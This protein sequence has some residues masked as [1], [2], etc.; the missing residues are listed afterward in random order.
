M[1]K[2]KKLVKITIT[3]ILTLSMILGSY[4]G[5]F[6]SEYGSIS[7]NSKTM[8]VGEVD[9]LYLDMELDGYYAKNVAWQS[10]SSSVTVV[11]KGYN[12]AWD[13]LAYEA[14][15][16]AAS[17]GT[18]TVTV[19]YDIV[20]WGITGWNWIFPIFGEIMIGHYQETCVVDV[21]E[22]YDTL[23]L[24]IDK[25]GIVNYIVNTDGSDAPAIPYN[26][27]EVYDITVNQSGMDL[28]VD[29]GYSSEYARVYGISLWETDTL[30]VTAKIKTNING[31]EVILDYSATFDSY[32]EYESIRTTDGFL[33]S[34][35]TVETRENFYTIYFYDE[36]GTTLLYTRV[37]K[38]GEDLID[39]P[40]NPTK[41]DEDKADGK[42]YYE[43]MEWIPMEMIFNVSLLVVEEEVSIF[44][45][46]EGTLYVR[47]TYSENKY[48]EVKF[49][50]QLTD[51]TRVLSSVQ[52]VKPGE[53]ATDPAA[54]LMAANGYTLGPWSGTFS[55]V[56]EDTEVT[57]RVAS[58]AGAVETGA[59]QPV[60]A[61]AAEVA[62]GDETP[63]VSM[64][65]LLI[66]ASFSI[67]F[68]TIRRR[69]SA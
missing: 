10:D 20:R 61:G 5:I 37:V 56:T 42:Y 65:I 34:D 67:I 58:V 31:Q 32:D 29:T 55:D 13:V 2:M 25:T 24:D 21:M 46:V 23:N 1:R 49:Y 11:D 22:Y 41:A 63:V 47:A 69:K 18:A 68:I 62:T 64:S 43:F 60:V 38:E 59:R 15:I 12:W 30:I 45:N 52:Y 27:A 44:E 48:V 39:F 50:V 19:D 6:A 17:R 66:A 3:T 51:G 26:D 14:E 36:D 16:T 53:D 9:S 40:P 54:A 35:P 4:V 8:D 33:I 57:A 28:I 7:S